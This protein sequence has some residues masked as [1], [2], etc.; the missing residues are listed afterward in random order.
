MKRKIYTQLV[1]WKN[2]ERRKPLVLNGVRQCGKTYILKEFF[3]SLDA[4]VF[5]ERFGII[6][7]V[8]LLPSS[9]A[10]CSRAYAH[11]R[12]VVFSTTDHPWWLC[13]WVVKTYMVFDVVESTTLRPPIDHQLYFSFPGSL[14]CLNRLPI[15]GNYI[16]PT[17]DTT[18]SQCLKS[19]LPNVWNNSFQRL[20]QPLSNVWQYYYPTFDNTIIQRLT[21]LLSNV[22]HNHYPTFDKTFVRR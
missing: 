7:I 1:D 20:T 18:L 17:F 22:W 9:F 13:F 6:A 19:L 5:L 14:T 21:I 11:A 12:C 16:Y 15:V 3:C 2:Q 10:W 8:F 4:Q